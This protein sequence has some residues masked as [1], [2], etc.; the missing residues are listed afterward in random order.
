M[1]LRDKTEISLRK[2]SGEITV[3]SIAALPGDAG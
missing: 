3:M 2:K 1:S